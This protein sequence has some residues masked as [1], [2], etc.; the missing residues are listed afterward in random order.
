MPSDKIVERILTLSATQFRN[1]SDR[2]PFLQ[3]GA[4]TRRGAR[5][6]NPRT[7]LRRGFDCL[8]ENSA[9]LSF[10]SLIRGLVI[11]SRT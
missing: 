10:A 11:A 8:G 6:E 1:A 7:L 9:E 4:E 5:F 2:D 3:A